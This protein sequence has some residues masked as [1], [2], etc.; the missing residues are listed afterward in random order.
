[1]LVPLRLATCIGFSPLLSLCVITERLRTYNVNGKFNPINLPTF[2]K[3]AS[4][5]PNTLLFRLFHA[6][7]PSRVEISQYVS[8]IGNGSTYPPFDCPLYFLIIS[9]ASLANGSDCVWAVAFLYVRFLRGMILTAL[10]PFFVVNIISSRNRT[11][12]TGRHCK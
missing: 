5:L 9:S 11:I 1:M 7:K 10:L 2:F 4:I 12:S 8:F 6:L 3:C